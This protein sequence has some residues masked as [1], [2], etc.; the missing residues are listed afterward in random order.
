MDGI[1]KWLTDI[2]LVTERMR[3][4]GSYGPVEFD[5]PA[6][7]GSGSIFWGHSLY[8]APDSADDPT[9]PMRLLAWMDVPPGEWP[10]MT[11][12]GGD[13]EISESGE[14]LT[15]EHRP[16]ADMISV[17]ATYRGGTWQGYVH[18]PDPRRRA[19]WSCWYVAVL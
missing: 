9:Y 2:C 14:W 6:D 8:I 18:V 17:A 12:S 10:Q 11:W 4:F 7:D 3:A 5:D 16:D 19:E 15:L 13:G 1:R